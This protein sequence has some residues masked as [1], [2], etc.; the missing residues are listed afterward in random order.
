MN[1]L[2]QHANHEQF[3]QREEYD[4]LLELNNI[5]PPIMEFLEET[6]FYIHND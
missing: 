6:S 2:H 1:S 5:H 3:Q 4:F